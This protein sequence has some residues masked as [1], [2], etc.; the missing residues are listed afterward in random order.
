MIDRSFGL[1]SHAPTPG[2]PL[3]VAAVFPS[4]PVAAPTAPLE[5]L[6]MVKGDDIRRNEPFEGPDAPKMATG[7]KLT[8]PVPQGVIS[9]TPPQ[10]VKGDR[11]P[12]R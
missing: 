6:K 9:S 10:M 5:P 4:A 7:H 2:T 3:H 11:L 1:P 12:S 8:A